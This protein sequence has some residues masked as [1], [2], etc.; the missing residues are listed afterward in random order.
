MN[1]NRR[2]LRKPAVLE[3]IGLRTTELYDLVR[4]GQFPAPVP[5]GKRAVAWIESEV[6]AWIEERVR[7][8]QER[9]GLNLND[10]RKQRC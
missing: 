3:R 8:R 5:L 4:E 10:L 6:E 1:L 9:R 7:M 2:L